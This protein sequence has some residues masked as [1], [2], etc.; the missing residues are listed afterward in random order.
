MLREYL[1]FRCLMA[2]ILSV[3]SFVNYCGAQATDPKIVEAAKKVGGE[4]EAYVTLRTGELSKI[5]GRV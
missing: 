3:V 5:F 2:V 1:K 4:I